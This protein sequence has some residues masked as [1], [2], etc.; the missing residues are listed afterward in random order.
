[1]VGISS[2][3]KGVLLIPTGI[4]KLNFNFNLRPASANPRELAVK[5]GGRARIAHPLSVGPPGL[6]APRATAVRAQRRT[7]G[8]LLRGRNQDRTAR[9]PR[10]CDVSHT[11]HAEAVHS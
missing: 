8:P 1:M 3:L 4:S 10:G 9:G 6:G 5:K 7:D 2:T 11:K